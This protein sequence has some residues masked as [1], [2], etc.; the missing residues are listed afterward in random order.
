MHS[1]MKG[2]ARPATLDWN[3]LKSFLATAEAGTLS[4]AARGLGLTQPTLGRQVA[5]L[6]QALDVKAGQTRPDGCSRGR[7]SR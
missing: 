7:E 1:C 2:A 3:H 5:A 6:E 4:A